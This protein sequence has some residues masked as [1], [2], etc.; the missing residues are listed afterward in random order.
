MFAGALNDIQ[1]RSCP[2]P[3]VVLALEQTQLAQFP[4]AKMLPELFK[5]Q[6]VPSQEAVQYDRALL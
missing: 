1:G 5:P 2:V 3:A 6:R 4:A